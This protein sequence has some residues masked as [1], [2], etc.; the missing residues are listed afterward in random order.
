MIA[1][2]Q[3][4]NTE[5][6]AFITGLVFQLLS[7]KVLLI[8]IKDNRNSQKEGCFLR[9]W[10]I[11]RVNYFKVIGNTVTSLRLRPML[12]MMQPPEC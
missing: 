8:N 11:S 5:I 10:Q 2:I 1:S 12:E 3:I 9:K 7:R 6:F 4:K